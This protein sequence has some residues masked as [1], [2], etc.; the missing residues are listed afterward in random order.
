[1]GGR[2]TFVL[3]VGL[4]YGVPIVLIVGTLALFLFA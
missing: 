4:M 2:D 3:I 1:M